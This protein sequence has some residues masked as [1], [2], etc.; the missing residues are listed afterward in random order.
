[1][2]LCDGGLYNPYGSRTVS[3]LEGGSEEGV[4]EVG[5]VDLQRKSHLI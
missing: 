3:Q 4:V 5:T 1:M 2:S